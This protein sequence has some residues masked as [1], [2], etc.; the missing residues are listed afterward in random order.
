MEKIPLLN[1]SINYFSHMKLS[2]EEELTHVFF[3]HKTEYKALYF[4]LYFS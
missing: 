4:L 1:F 3:K 2:Y